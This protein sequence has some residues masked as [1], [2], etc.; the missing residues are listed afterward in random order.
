MRV[1]VANLCTFFPFV[2]AVDALS[3]QNDTA[4][5]PFHQEMLMQ[6]PFH[7]RQWLQ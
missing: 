6:L 1:H 2:H 7:H 4:D 5:A 3:P